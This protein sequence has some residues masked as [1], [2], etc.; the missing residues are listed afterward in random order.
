MEIASS[1]NNFKMDNYNR[2]QFLKN[3]IGLAAF[4]SF[5]ENLFKKANAKLSFSTL[6]CPDWPFDKILEMAVKN[7]YKGIELRGIKRELDLPLCAEFAN[8]AAI[9]TTIKKIKD[10]NLQIVDLGSGANL[11][12]FDTKKRNENMDHAKRFIDLAA[13][14]DCPFV[15]VFPNDLPKDQENSKTID[16]I[17]SNLIELGEYARGAKVKVLMETHGKV[18]YKDTLLQIMQATAQN[19]VGL[20]WDIW[21]MWSVTKEPP[22]KVYQLLKKYIH[23]THIKD[24]IF[25]NEKPKYVLLGQ[26]ISPLKEA[27][28]LLQKGGYKGYYSL[29]WEK[30][31]HPEIE[32]PEIAIP[33]YAAKFNKLF[34]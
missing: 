33:H 19:N 29:E 9:A 27:I 5:E 26:G 14:I 2:R 15:R 6:G 31:W 4:L 30:M 10:N 34:G 11:H 21:N 24:G 13:K 7:G 23:H 16:L 32:E 12:Y 1:I 3:G 20:I 17:I 28:S 8:A 22:T 25:V 18:I